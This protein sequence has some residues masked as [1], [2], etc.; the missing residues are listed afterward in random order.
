M[1]R[2][3]WKALEA[4]WLAGI[5]RE[6]L[7][8]KHGISKHAL[9]EQI[10]AWKAG[11]LV[12]RPRSADLRA[13][14]K[15]DYLAGMPRDKIAA[16]HG[17]AAQTVTYWA[18]RYWPT[19]RIRPHRR[20]WTADDEAIMREMFEAGALG[21][22]I[23][24]RLGREQHFVRSKMRRAGLKRSQAETNRKQWQRPEFRERFLAGMAERYGHTVAMAGNLP[25][26][27]DSRAGWHQQPS[28]APNRSTGQIRAVS[29]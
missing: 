29:P 16:K 8:W 21:T 10:M 22:D 1:S 14:V 13:A 6:M 12:P 7:Q 9:N 19:E 20:R 5:K 2:I 11:G 3:D 4:D 25:V 28:E 18:A 17:I 26:Q 27:H 23:A 15:A 24:A